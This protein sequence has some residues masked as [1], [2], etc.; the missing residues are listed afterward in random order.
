MYPMIKVINIEIPVYGIIGILAFILAYFYARSKARL[1]NID[2]QDVLYAACYGAVGLFIGAKLLYFLA[3]LPKFVSHIDEVILHPKEAIEYFLGGFVFYGG[4]IGLLIGVI[5]Y[6]RKFQLS[7][8]SYANIIAPGILIVHSLGRIGC[9]FAGCC[10]GIEYDGPLSIT[11]PVNHFTMEMAG[12][13][14]FP[15]QLL[16]SLLNLLM[17]VVLFVYGRK[18]RPEGQLLGI[19]L[20]FYSTVRFA[21]EYVRADAVRGVF[22]GI[23]TSQW[24]SLGLLPLGMII[25]IYST[26]REKK[27]ADRRNKVVSQKI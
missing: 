3:L 5:I 13:P 27:I 9:F 15:V 22:W 2:K 18:K 10:Y 25:T 4:L 12:V 1:Y 11:F 16:E 19:Y 14:R 26:K 20:I 24:I 6:C 8:I 7:V 17:F 21:L 23:S